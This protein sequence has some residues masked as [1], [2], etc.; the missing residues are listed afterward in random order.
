[1]TRREAAVIGAYTGIL[2]GPFNDL[3]QYIEEIM[4]RPVQTAELANE[5]LAEEIKQKAKPDFLNLT[6]DDLQAPEQ[7]TNK[8]SEDSFIVSLKDECPRC[9]SKL[10]AYKHTPASDHPDIYSWYI[11]C[12]SG[13]CKY[14]YEDSFSTLA[15]MCR[16]FSIVQL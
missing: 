6:I 1:M 5:A 3:H 16:E 12:E 10:Y 15:D 9:A 11:E 8:I 14:E 4:G 13:S 2:C 7:V